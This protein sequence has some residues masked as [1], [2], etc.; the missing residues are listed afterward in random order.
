[1]NMKNKG[2][3][4]RQA[5][6]TL[7]ELMVAIAILAILSAVGMMIFRTVQINSR[8]EK[9]LRDLNS[10]KQA[11]ELYRSEWKSYPESLEG[12]KGLFLEDI[13][14]DPSGGV[15][16]YQYKMDS[17]SASFVLCALKEGTNEF[18]N[19]TDCGT[20]YCLSPGT[21]CNMGISSD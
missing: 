4:C 5:G 3:A 12:L 16:S 9:R 1:M 10:L 11:L 2:P 15:R 13:P 19:P 21:P 17:G 8:D 18:G 14:R 20:L 7:I 6:F